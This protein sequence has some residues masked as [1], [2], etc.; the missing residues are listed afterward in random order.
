MQQI[1]P[2]PRYAHINAT[3]KVTLALGD[4]GDARQAVNDIN[5]AGGNISYTEGRG[6]LSRVF[7]F[8][9]NA[10]SLYYLRDRIDPDFRNSAEAKKFARDVAARGQKPEK[11]TEQGNDAGQ[12]FAEGVRKSAARFKGTPGF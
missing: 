10:E 1:K 6:A 9:G 3:L 12:R 5:L 4:Y 7:T 8:H 11:K 2:D